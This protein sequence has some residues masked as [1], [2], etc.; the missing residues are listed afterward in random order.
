[1]RPTP[2]ERFALSRIFHEADDFSRAVV[3]ALDRVEV[4]ARE[5]TGVGFFTTLRFPAQLPES[6]R[7]QWDWNFTHRALPYGGSFVCW[8]EGADSLLLEAVA[9]EGSWP[10]SFQPEEFATR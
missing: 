8:L 6:K 2:E 1:M 7:A 9:H 4:V 3:S 10:E 5:S